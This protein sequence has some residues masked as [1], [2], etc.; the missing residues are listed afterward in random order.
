MIDPMLL[1]AHSVHAN[2]GAYA[3]LLGS[4]VSSAAGV[5]TGWAITEDLVVRISQLEGSERPEDPAA[6]Y[7]E[8]F[9]RAAAYSD[10]LDTLTSTPAER[11]TM[12]RAYIEPTADERASGLKVPTTAHRAIAELVAH[13]YVRIVVTT[14]FDRL[15]EQALT[16]IGVDYDVIAST[17]AL[18]GVRPVGQA[19]CH[20]IKVHGDYKDSRILNTESELLAYPSEIDA[21]LDRILDEHGLIV[22]GWSATWDPALRAALQRQPN[23]RYPMWW[24]ARGP[25][26]A[27]AAHLVTARGATVVDSVNADAFFDALR[28]KI[29]ALAD[30]AR[31]HPLAASAA[32]AELKRYLPDPTQR[33]RHRDLVVTE[34]SRLR[35]A[36]ADANFPISGTTLDFSFLQDRLARYEAA[37]EIAVSMFAVGGAWS[38]DYAPYVEALDL[39]ASPSSVWS[40]QTLLLHL[41]RYPALLCLYAGGLAAVSADN[42][43]M[44]RA[45]SYDRSAFIDAHRSPMAAALNPWEVVQ[46]IDDVQWLPGQTNQKTPLSNVLFKVLRE[47]LRDVIPSDDRYMEVFDA[48]ECLLGLIIQDQQNQGATHHYRASVG[49]FGWRNEFGF[50]ENNKRLDSVITEVAAQGSEW[51]PLKAGLFGGS[52]DRFQAAALEYSKTVAVMSRR[53]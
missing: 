43:S 25:L 24:L 49:C 42:W 3:L 52:V 1:L 31:P 2:P 22:C 17:D 30:V 7:L 4:G 5:P 32:V 53:F 19:P 34:A 37:G 6:W 16:D 9:G 41:R 47:P 35:D 51:P 20:I 50:S 15:L 36:L 44:L 29:D 33:L 27:E 38:D 40:G 48:F 21:L 26:S 39:V 45:L 18:R 13:G 28:S 23:R 11:Q 46:G 12:L 10:L 14:N 8:R